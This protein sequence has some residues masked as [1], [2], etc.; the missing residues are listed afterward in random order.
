MALGAHFKDEDIATQQEAAVNSAHYV[1]SK[2]CQS[3]HQDIYARWVKTRM[4]NVLRDPKVHPDAFAAD[5]ATAPA[6]L[7]FTKDEVTFIYGSKWKQRYWKKAGD[8]YVPLLAQFNIATK[9]WSKYHV[10]D[11]GD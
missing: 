6:D 11:T 4:A 2:A 3:C 1:G 10:P 9:K 7:R 5:P 8:T